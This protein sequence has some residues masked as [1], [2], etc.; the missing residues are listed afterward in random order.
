MEIRRLDLPDEKAMVDRVK[1]FRQ[2]HT[3]QTGLRRRLLLIET[4]NDVGRER[5]KSGDGG[6]LASKPVL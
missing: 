1:R 3:Q 2:V 4:S 6:V 5:E